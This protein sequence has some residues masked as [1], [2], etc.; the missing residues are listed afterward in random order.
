M[1]LLIILRLTLIIV[2]LSLS[3]LCVSVITVISIIM[4]MIFI[5]IVII[6][7]IIITTG[8]PWSLTECILNA[9][10]SRPYYDPGAD[11]ANYGQPPLTTASDP[12][13]SPVDPALS[14][15]KTVASSASTSPTEADPAASP[16]GVK[17]EEEAE[18]KD[19]ETKPKKPPHHKLLHVAA[20]LEM[21][22]L[23]DEFDQL[24]TEMIVTKAGRWVL[25]LMT[26]SPNNPF[27]G[28]ISFIIIFKEPVSMANAEV[29]LV[30][31][32]L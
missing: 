5:I 18:T 24:G 8:V 13:C 31:F 9:G 20:Q 22:A 4:V 17:D 25:C 28:L 16:Q 6:I 21:K 15:G 26:F 2:L 10:T 14:P 19:S 12:G 23:W 30:S 7:I 29:L 32:T 27:P 1:I 11:P 3:L